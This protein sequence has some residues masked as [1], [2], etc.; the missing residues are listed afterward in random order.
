MVE[1]MIKLLEAKV[2]PS[3]RRG[4]HPDRD[5]GRRVGQIM[6]AIASE[7]EG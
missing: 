6:R 5:T 4:K 7:L 2:Q 1:D 3:L